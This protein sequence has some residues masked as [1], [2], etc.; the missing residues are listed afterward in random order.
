ML[1]KEYNK[2]INRVVDYI[3]QHISEELT[4]QTLLVLV[5]YSPFHF[6]RIFTSYMG[7][8]LAKYVL[9]RRLELAA[10]ILINSDDAPIM[11]IAC[12]VGFNST[13]VFCRNFK[14]KFGVTAEEYRHNNC[15]SNSKNRTFERNNSPE[16]RAYSHYLCSRKSLLIKDEKMKKIECT[17]EIKKLP[18]LHIAY[19][20]HYGAYNKMDSAFVKLIQWAYSK[21]LVDPSEKIRLLSVYHDNPDVTKD[22]KKLISDAAMVIDP[23]VKTDGE[24]GAYDLKEGLYAVG[25]FEISME[26]FPEA[27]G[28]MHQLIAE[29]GSQYSEGLPYEIYLNNRDE[30]PERKWIVDICI[31]VR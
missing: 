29:Y 6:H 14:R 16:D 25:R 8:S 7:E 10:I 4:I 19:S 2:Q 15:L 13:N 12:D 3:N 31:P 20:R 18:T 26:E 11:N 17:F 22:E 24:I 1:N 21:E 9:R 30:H 23:S 5:D 27:W 28:C